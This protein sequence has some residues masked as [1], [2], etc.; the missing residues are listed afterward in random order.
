MS[1]ITMTGTLEIGDVIAAIACI[2]SIICAVFT[3]SQTKF[4]KKEYELQKKVYLEGLAKL[5]LNIRDCFLYN[6]KNEN[7]IFI[8]FGIVISNLSDKQTSIKKCILSLLCEDNIIYKPDLCDTYISIYEGLNYLNI[9]MNMEA[10][11]STAGWVKFALSREIYEK[12]DINM[13]MLSV[14]EIH[15][16]K[17]V[18][19]AVFVR[20]E[21]NNYEIR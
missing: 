21:I 18:D 10:H 7:N 6:D 9:P 14:E 12:L 4:A 13:F 15:G 11:S 19:N 17:Q 20:E 16:I 2:I 5:E 1:E 8:F 3:F